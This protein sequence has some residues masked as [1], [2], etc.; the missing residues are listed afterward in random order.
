M[1]SLYV[2]LSVVAVGAALV[3]GQ[4]VSLPAHYSTVVA[5]YSFK[6]QTTSIQPVIL[7]TPNEAGIYRISEYLITNGKT[8]NLA[9]ALTSRLDVTR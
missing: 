9:G 1:K 8:G 2:L 3:V 4:T 5:S 6:N 7:V